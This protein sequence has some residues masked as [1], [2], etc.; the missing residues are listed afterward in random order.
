VDLTDYYDDVSTVE[1]IHELDE[2]AARWT[3]IDVQAIRGSN[4]Y[5]KQKAEFRVQCSKMS[6]P[7]PDGTMSDGAPCWLCSAPIDYRLSHPHPES[8]SLDHAKTV[9]E[10]PELI[11]DVANWRAAHLDCNQRR[12]TDEP[13]IDLGEPSRMW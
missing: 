4:A 3:H 10:A 7:L 6:V 2:S 13:F 9:K 5:K 11:M 1:P 8:W 12:G